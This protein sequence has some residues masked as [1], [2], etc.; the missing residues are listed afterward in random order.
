M[1]RLVY[2]G[3]VCECFPKFRPRRRIICN[4]GL[5]RFHLNEFGFLIQLC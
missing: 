2:S 3:G 5:N 4:Y 1:G